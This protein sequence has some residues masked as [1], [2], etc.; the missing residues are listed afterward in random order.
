MTHTSEKT[1][2]WVE[3]EQKKIAKERYEREKADRIKAVE[4]S[5]SLMSGSNLPNKKVEIIEVSKSIYN[6]IVNG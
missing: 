1:T 3:E 6:Y 4:L 5:V 2:N